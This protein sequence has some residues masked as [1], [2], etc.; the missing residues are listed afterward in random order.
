MRKAVLIQIQF[1]EEIEK[2]NVISDKIKIILK[3][4]KKLQIVDLQRFQ[5]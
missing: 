5:L 4:K 1:L 3:S 2:S